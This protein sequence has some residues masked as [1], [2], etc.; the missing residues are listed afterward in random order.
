MYGKF[1][2]RAHGNCFLFCE[3]CKC[4]VLETDESTADTRGQSQVHCTGQGSTTDAKKKTLIFSAL[5]VYVVYWYL[6][7]KTFTPQWIRQPK[8]R[9]CVFGVGE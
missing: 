3:C 9:G 8:P 1:N 6:I 5:R 4:I 2:E 7:Q